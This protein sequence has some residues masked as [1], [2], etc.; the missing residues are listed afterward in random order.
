MNARYGERQD[1]RLELGLSESLKVKVETAAK[2][3]F[4]NDYEGGYSRSEFMRTAAEV[5]L[6]LID[7][8]DEETGLRDLDCKTRKYKLKRWLEDELGEKFIAGIS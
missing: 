6:V 1:Q 5:L 3:M 8:C 7:Q 4:S 2:Q